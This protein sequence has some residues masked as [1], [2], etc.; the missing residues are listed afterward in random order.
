MSRRPRHTHSAAFK[1]KVA[2]SA[3]RGDKT[4]AEL[5][6]L[7]DVH[8]NQITDWKN[9]LLAR[10]V[11]V[12]GGE[13]AKPE[14][15]IDL[16]ALHAEIGQLKLE[17]D[18]LEGVLIK[19]RHAE[20]ETMIDPDHNLPIRRQAQ[21]VNISRGSVYYQAKLVSDADLALMRRIDELHLKLLFA[22]ARM[23]RGEGVC[24]CGPQAHDHAE[25]APGITAPYRK[26]NTSRKAPGHILYPYLLKEVFVLKAYEAVGHQK[27]QLLRM[28][29]LVMTLLIMSC[30][31]APS[32]LTCCISLLRASSL[33]STRRAP[34]K[35]FSQ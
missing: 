12:F 28:P 30:A 11:D 18:F 31:S 35:R 23:L 14:P 25:A 16:K 21:L 34:S 7:Y 17:N 3:I 9:Q 10:A 20:R 4:L 27:N 2:L 5:A 29:A 1:A 33:S 6:Q 32:R 13:Q 15:A 22:G 24:R 8:P 19:R 26:P